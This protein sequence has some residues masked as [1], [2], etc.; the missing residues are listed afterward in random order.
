MG[1]VYR[2]LC[3]TSF[4]ESRTCGRRWKSLRERVA[5]VEAEFNRGGIDDD[6]VDVDNVD[7]GNEERQRTVAAPRDLFPGL[8]REQLEPG[9]EPVCGA[10]ELVA[11]WRQAWAGRKRP[12]NTQDWLRAERKGWGWSFD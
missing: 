8:F 7:D 1:P 12:H 11:E 3:I 9:E 4:E 2:S 5:V 10:A 6:G